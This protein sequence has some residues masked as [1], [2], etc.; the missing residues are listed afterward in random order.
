MRP[1]RR[2]HDRTN[3]METR[4]TAH[5]TGRHRTPADDCS[6][7]RTYRAEDSSVARVGARCIYGGPSRCWGLAALLSAASLSSIGFSGLRDPGSQR[8]PSWVCRCGGLHRLRAARVRHLYG[9]G[10][11]RPHV[12]GTEMILDDLRRRPAERDVQGVI[13]AEHGILKVIV[14]LQ[15]PHPETIDR[16]EVFDPNGSSVRSKTIVGSIRAKVFRNFGGAIT[17]FALGDPGVIV[18]EHVLLEPPRDDLLRS[19]RERTGRQP[20]CDIMWRWIAVQS[21]GEPRGGSQRRAPSSS[22]R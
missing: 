9:E 1:D 14:V 6:L 19:A 13:Q 21:S 2:G 20:S 10:L 22:P 18:R 5:R 16:L 8:R 15:C 3:R 11:H 17:A 4:A 7:P 12:T